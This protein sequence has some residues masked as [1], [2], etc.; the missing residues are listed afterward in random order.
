MTV[1]P[2]VRSQILDAAERRCASAAP[3]RSRFALRLR[4]APLIAAGAALV[5]VGGAFGAGVIRIGAAAKESRDFSNPRA[6]LGSIARGSVAMMPLQAP[7]PAG[8]LPWGM[9]VLSTTRGVG[10]IQVGR[11]L[12]GKLGALGRDGIFHDDGRFHELPAKGAFD[13]FACSALD[14]NGRIFNNVTVGEEPASGAWLYARGSCVAPHA[15]RYENP[16]HRR[17]CPIADERNLYY[18]MLGPDAVSVTYVTRGQSRTIPTVGGEGAYL[19]VTR[20]ARRQLFDFGGLG[21]SGVVPVDSPITELHYR[22]GSTCHL[23]SRRMGGASACTPPMSEPVG[24]VPASR[25][26]TRAQVAA[27]LRVKV[28]R[29]RG[30]EQLIV[31]FRSPIAISSDRANY[32]LAYHEPRMPPQ[33]NGYA[34]VSHADVRAGQ[35]I[36]VRIGGRG[37]PH[38]HG[39][40]R[41]SVVLNYANGPSLYEGPGTLKLTVGSFTA[42]VP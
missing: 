29:V 2:A 20:A 42:R 14:A 35:L 39:L 10:C 7:D 24:Y 38:V 4:R 23:R 34:P 8:G 17:R 26:P 19:I 12:D 37:G 33:V 18:G 3:R 6:E 11:V 30:G 9:R 25:A 36:T 21:T 40:V 41:G 27:P 13:P 22:D 28:R 1:L 5:L 31:S 15:D 32:M 16:E